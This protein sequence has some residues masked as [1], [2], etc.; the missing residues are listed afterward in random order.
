M[1]L[2]FLLGLALADHPLAAIFWSWWSRAGICV[3]HV[4]LRWRADVLSV[5][6]LNRLMTED[7]PS[8]DL[9]WITATD[10]LPDRCCTCGMYSDH[11]AKV[12]Q[13]DF[14]TKPGGPH[15]C[16]GMAV[17]LVVNLALGP[18]GWLISM[19][20]GL[21][22]DAKEKTV[23]R[24]YRVRIPQCRLCNGVAPPEITDFSAGPPARFAFSVHPEFRRR[25]EQQ[26]NDPLE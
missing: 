14:V 8:Q 11:R 17:F 3:A 1:G 6:V 13:T 12:Q 21:D 19:L 7:L 22:G 26:P 4:C 2:E 15:G 16:I 20:L 10:A 23:K 9:I 25:W 24:K 18:L 5:D